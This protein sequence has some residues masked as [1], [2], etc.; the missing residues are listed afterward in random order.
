MYDGLC[1]DIKDWK[2]FKRPET[3]GYVMRP[4]DAFKLDDFNNN[5]VKWVRPNHVQTDEHW[6]NKEV[7]VNG[8]A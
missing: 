7:E 6:M 5:V 1:K 8:L 4:A 2:I 3:E